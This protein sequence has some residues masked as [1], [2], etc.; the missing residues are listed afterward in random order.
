M[1][2][3]LLAGKHVG[4]DYREAP[5]PD[6]GKY[7][8][9]TYK[10][11]DVIEAENNLAETFVLG[12]DKFQLIDT[13]DFAAPKPTATRTE[14]VGKPVFEEDAGL[15]AQRAQEK[16]EGGS[17]T[18]PKEAAEDV[19][20]GDASRRSP[21]PLHATHPASGAGTGKQGGPSGRK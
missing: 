10:A 16:K 17:G 4:P 1:K 5:N 8:S 13:S 19:L 15:K 3:R 6:T 20:E 11:G 18:T 12:R 7:P 14:V 21:Q 2:F 9:R